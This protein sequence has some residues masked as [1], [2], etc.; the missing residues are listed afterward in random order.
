MNGWRPRNER[1]IDLAREREAAARIEQAWGRSCIK[2]SE[3]LYEIDWAFFRE[4]QLVGWGEYKWRERRY[5]TL[6]LGAAKWLRGQSLM[7]TSGRPFLLFIEWP[8]GLYW[9]NAEEFKTMDI[10]LSGNSRGQNGD[11]E[12]CVHIPI[13]LFKKLRP[14]MAIA[15]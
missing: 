9:L 12:P 13:S 5:D 1:D 15:A 4:G 3:R 8:D 10:R 6:L 2:L 7:Q 11:I 14:A